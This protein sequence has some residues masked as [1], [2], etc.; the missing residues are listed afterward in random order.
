MSGKPSKKSAQGGNESWVYLKTVK[1]QVT[2][3]K[4]VYKYELERRQYE[5]KRQRGEY[6][7]EPKMEETIYLKRTRVVRVVKFNDG[8]VSSWEDPPGK[9][10]DDWHQ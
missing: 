8:R 3:K 5:E 6:A 10:L 4:D 2:Q 7:T 9:Y 1:K